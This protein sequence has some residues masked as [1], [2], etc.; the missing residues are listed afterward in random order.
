M[1]KSLLLSIARC[2]NV[3]VCKEGSRARHPCREVVSVQESVPLREHQ[4]PEPWNGD[5]ESAPILFV[6][7]NPGIS[8]EEHYPTTSWTDEAIHDFFLHRFGGGKTV[9]M[10]DGVHWL[11]KDGTRVKRAVM[12]NAQAKSAARLLLE[13]PPVPGVDYVFTEIVHCKSEAERGVAEAISECGERYLPR[14]LAA[15]GARAIVVYGGQ[16]QSFM[17]SAF[18]APSRTGLHGPISL[19]NRERWLINLPHPNARMVRRIDKVLGAAALARARA[20]VQGRA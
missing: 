9:W 18:A 1:S 2:P 5:L 8:L 6:S 17:A 20:V 12:F 10:K 11:K 19:G 15:S 13:R 14:I 16:A 4:L 3:A 7:S